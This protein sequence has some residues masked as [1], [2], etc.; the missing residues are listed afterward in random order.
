MK[1]KK[2]DQETDLGATQSKEKSVFEL[3]EMLSKTDDV[4]EALRFEE[5]ICKKINESNVSEIKDLFSSKDRYCNVAALRILSDSGR[6]GLSNAYRYVDPLFEHDDLVLKRLCL[7]LIEQHNYYHT[8][9]NKRMA[10]LG[11]F[12]DEPI[13][14]SVRVWLLWRTVEELEEFSTASQPLNEQIEALI[15]L[16]VSFKSKKMG[17]E[18]FFSS[19]SALDDIAFREYTRLSKQKAGRAHTVFHNK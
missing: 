4:D 19:L 13:K 17:V 2:G 10:Q 16:I 9:A 8:S 15:G 11:S 3:A 1:R 12:P 6:V 5:M 18:D 14:R 7:S